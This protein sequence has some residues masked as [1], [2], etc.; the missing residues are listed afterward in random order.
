MARKGISAVSEVTGREQRVRLD[1]TRVR[2]TKQGTIKS[3]V[4]KAPDVPVVN[5]VQSNT[6]QILGESLGVV[7]GIGA[8]ISQRNITKEN[9]KQEKMIAIRQTYAGNR[10]ATE[11]VHNT[12]EELENIASPKGKQDYL[13][14][15]M[16]RFQNIFKNSKDELHPSYYAAGI[17]TIAKNF[18]ALYAGFGKDE[19]NRQAEENRRNVRSH[20]TNTVAESG[21]SVASAVELINGA[22]LSGFWSSSPTPKTD[23]ARFVIKTLMADFRQRKE[24]DPSLSAVEFVKVLNNIHSPDLVV[25]KYAAT[26]LIGGD[27]DAFITD[28]TNLEAAIKTKNDNEAKVAASE[29][30]KMITNILLNENP[31][32]E[33]FEKLIELAKSTADGRPASEHRTLLQDIADRRG[34]DHPSKDIY[35]L[36]ILYEEMSEGKYDNLTYAEVIRITR[37]LSKK[38]ADDF[39]AAWKLKVAQ[40]RTQAGRVNKDRVMAFIKAREKGVSFFDERGNLINS[41]GFS[42]RAAVSDWEDSH[43]GEKIDPKTLKEFWT[44]ITE[45]EEVEGTNQR[46]TSTSTAET[47]L[48]PDPN[49]PTPSHLTSSSSPKVAAG[50]STSSPDS[51][52][53]TKR[54]EK[55]EAD[56]STVIKGIQDKEL[57]EEDLKLVKRQGGE[58]DEDYDGRVR[59]HLFNLYLEGKEKEEVDRAK[60]VLDNRVRILNEPN[61]SELQ[62]KYGGS[63]TE[64]KEKRDAE[65]KAATDLIEKINKMESGGTAVD[66]KDITRSL[67]ESL[68][69]ALDKTT[70]YIDA[71]PYETALT[72]LSLFPLTGAGVAI[73]GGTIKGAKFIKAIAEPL[74]KKGLFKSTAA[75]EKV[76][77]SYKVF[78][79]NGKVW[80]GLSSGGKPFASKVRAAEELA[81][82]VETKPFKARGGNPKD[83]EVVKVSGG[84][85][86]APTILRASINLGKSALLKGAVPIAGVGAFASNVSDV[87]AAED[88]NAVLDKAIAADKAKDP[89]KLNALVEEEA[90]AMALS[91]DLSA[92]SKEEEEA[93]AEA[94]SRYTAEVNRIQNEIDTIQN[95]QVRWQGLIDTMDAH[96]PEAVAKAEAPDTST[97]TNYTESDVLSS[98]RLSESGAEV[99]ADG[100]YHI[101]QETLNQY[102]NNGKGIKNTTQYGVVVKDYKNKEGKTVKGFPK[103][104]GETD[105]V[106]A[107][108]IWRT[109]F[110]PKFKKVKGIN[111]ASKEVVKVVSA[112]LWNRGSLPKSLDLTKQKSV[113]NTFLGVTTTDGKHSTGIVNTAIRRYNA[114]ASAQGTWDIISYVETPFTTG[115]EGV[116]KP[117]FYDAAGKLLKA[118]NRSSTSATNASIKGGYKYPIK[119]D[120][121]LDSD[122]K[123]LLK[124]AS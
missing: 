77:S 25:G 6:G 53:V 97:V 85:Q 34:L 108:R 48:T 82:R 31:P 27:I 4:L 63:V 32:A 45:V 2:E 111:L 98:I 57:T 75:V 7:A 33:A 36:G 23:A 94:K 54:N 115:N 68:R 121:S 92:L 66:A 38:S 113:K 96:P 124:A 35:S 83:W 19:D 39:T 8:K 116:Y 119:A 122:K 13:L 12:R 73:V 67:N 93:I 5:P 9:E 72:A 21:I 123:Q 99:I 50:A 106:H 104:T 22:Q 86:V 100:V 105:L 47:T 42:L 24:Q 40:A 37:N 15:S 118:A 91:K 3:E 10:F 59:G 114:I 20:I 46:S 89:H 41:H 16:N 49:N 90:K 95:E 117:H 65:V 30:S 79:N 52:E 44:A 120:S 84:Y 29:A 18:D 102:N 17:N 74:V 56:Y 109:K 64:A 70:A 51:E 1:K 62:F 28:I 60:S 88:P 58:S 14:K 103:L 81:R 76:L 43:V 11:F 107:T 112:M 80:N 69:L 101:G 110:L 61:D 71:H 55:L 26:G 87:E 78:A